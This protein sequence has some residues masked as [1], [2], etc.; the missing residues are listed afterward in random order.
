MTLPTKPQSPPPSPAGG[1]GKRL[2]MQINPPRPAPPG[3]HRARSSE[4]AR[5]TGLLVKR[6]SRVSFRAVAVMTAIVT[7]SAG[8]VTAGVGVATAQSGSAST[9]KPLTVK[10]KAART[11]FGFQVPKNKAENDRKP[12]ELGLRF[13]AKVPGTIR[14]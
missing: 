8:I 2:S 10:H 13:R 11:I 6:P 5:A 1:H 9:A 14:G 12:T 7:A 3:R 4:P